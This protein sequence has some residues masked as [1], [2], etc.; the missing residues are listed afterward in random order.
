MASDW[1]REFGRNIFLHLMYIVFWSVFSVNFSTFRL[2]LWK[3]DKWHQ[4]YSELD[5][6]QNWSNSR[7]EHFHW[8]ITITIQLNVLVE[9]Y[10]L[11][12]STCSRYEIA[13]NFLMLAFNNNQ[14]LYPHR[15][16]Y[17]AGINIGRLYNAILSIVH[18]IISQLICKW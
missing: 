10:L 3:Q 4:P 11:I 13:G 17:N 2:L 6:M 5:W 7:F 9:R 1:L 16:Q 12:D 15:W 18:I 14:S 8:A